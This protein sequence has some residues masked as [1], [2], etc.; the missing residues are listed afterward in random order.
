MWDHAYKTVLLTFEAEIH[1]S[2]LR[3]GGIERVFATLAVT[4]ES[5]LIPPTTINIFNSQNT[6]NVTLN[7]VQMKARD[8]RN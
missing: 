5:E 8:L 2:G 6:Q 3:A 7:Y 4:F 1:D